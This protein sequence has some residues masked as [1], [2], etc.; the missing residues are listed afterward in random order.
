M[1]KLDG[2]NSYKKVDLVAGRQSNTKSVFTLPL[3][4]DILSVE[5][6]LDSSAYSQW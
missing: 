3:I 2:V 5:G 1:V 6:V 4:T